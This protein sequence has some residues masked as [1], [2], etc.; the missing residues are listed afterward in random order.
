M[1][2]KKRG[3]AF[4]IGFFTLLG[5]VLATMFLNSVESFAEKVEI[6]FMLVTSI[7]ITACVFGVYS[8]FADAFFRM[9]ENPKTYLGIC[10]AVIFP[11]AIVVIGE[12][13]K[14]GT[15]LKEGKV[16]FTPWGNLVNV[17]TFLVIAVAIIIKMIAN[18]KEEKE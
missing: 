1:Q 16:T 9:N 14:N 4:R 10:F 6:D 5:C 8:V 17:V 13:K 3:D 15:L 18:K 12:L 11:N 2:L 7:M